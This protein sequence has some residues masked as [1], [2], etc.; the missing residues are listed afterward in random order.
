MEQE[1]RAADVEM[2]G[3]SLC[4]SWTFIWLLNAGFAG[5]FGQ[6]STPGR[7]PDAS[8]HQ[9]LMRHN[10]CL[11]LA[12][13][14]TCDVQ[15]DFKGI[16]FKQRPLQAMHSLIFTSAW[17]SG[18]PRPP[19]QQPLN[20]IQEPTYPCNIVMQHRQHLQLK[21]L[22]WSRLPADVRWRHNTEKVLAVQ[23][24]WWLR[25]QLQSTRLSSSP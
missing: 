5:V 2:G 12:I 7:S 14:L 6:R 4:V 19:L 13:Y 3:L 18:R 1:R 10:E 25:R 8:D 24:T 11:M 21:K 23:W 17:P 20:S 15:L 16:P 9:I 22:V